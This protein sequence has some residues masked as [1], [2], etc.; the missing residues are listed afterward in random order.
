MS[1]TQYSKH[2]AHAQSKRC[3]WK[4]WGRKPHVSG[5]AFLFFIK[6]PTLLR[7][8]ATASPW[9]LCHSRHYRRDLRSALPGSD[10]Q[11][12]S[13]VSSP[14][15]RRRRGCQDLRSEE[16]DAPVT[17]CPACTEGCSMSSASPLSVPLSSMRNVSACSRRTG[18]CSCVS[19][20]LVSIGPH[21]VW[22]PDTMVL[23]F[24]RLLVSHTFHLL[25]ST[26]F[27]S[28]SPSLSLSLSLSFI[29]PLLCQAF[30]DSWTSG[31]LYQQTRGQFDSH[32]EVPATAS[33][34]NLALAWQ[35]VYLHVWQ[36]L[37]APPLIKMQSFC[38]ARASAVQTARGKPVV[39]LHSSLCP[40][41]SP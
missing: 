22:S 23:C 9:Q 19:L 16:L 31:L 6:P 1:M 37:A 13:A 36:E 28:S 30:Q 11:P 35:P 41:V 32:E 26:S 24:L 33:G 18:A 2:N 20:R 14:C 25:F 15:P 29:G 7:G 10:F 34:V 3:T 17:R 27:F 40:C 21:H 4:Q 8:T 5:W 39:Y 12:A 38:T